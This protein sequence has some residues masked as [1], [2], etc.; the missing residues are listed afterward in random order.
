M[1]YFLPF[2]QAHIVPPFASGG[3]RIQGLLLRTTGPIESLEEP[4]RRLV[5]DGRTDLPFLRVRPYTELMEPQIRPWRN[6]T[7]LLTLFSGLALVVA[8]VGLYAAFAH[9]VGERRREMAIRIAIGARPR[10]V[11]LMILREATMLGLRRNSLRE[12]GGDYRRTVGPVDAVRHERIGPTGA[13]SRRGPHA[14]RRR[15]GNLPSRPHGLACRSE[16]APAR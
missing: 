10:G 14:A 9:S 11:L 6:G 1:Q 3:P 5:A 12:R 13:R 2:S 15:S 7:A 4:I 8:A 16:R